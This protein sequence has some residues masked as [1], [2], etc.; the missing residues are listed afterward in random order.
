M[1]AGL[2]LEHPP[3]GRRLESLQ[4]KDGLFVALLLTLLALVVHFVF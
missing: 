4:E 2:S 1:M 3:T